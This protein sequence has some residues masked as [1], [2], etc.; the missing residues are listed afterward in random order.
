MA[1]DDPPQG[2]Q[3]QAVE[4]G[5]RAYWQ[6]FLSSLREL[7]NGQKP[8]FPGQPTW[9]WQEVRPIQHSDTWTWADMRLRG[10]RN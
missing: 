7:L 4:P 3:T 1:P 2:S 10:V 8:R 9:A 5:G 6:T